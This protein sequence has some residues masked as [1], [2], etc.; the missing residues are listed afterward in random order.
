MTIELHQ[1]K[2]DFDL[3]NP[4]PFCMKAETFMKLAGVD[5]DLKEWAPTKAPLG[6]APVLSIDNELTPDSSDIIRK[7]I[8]TQNLDIDGSVDPM[9]LDLARMATRILEEHSYWGLLFLRWIDDDGWSKYRPIIGSSIGAPSFILPVI[10][11]ML[12]RN[13]KRD[14]KGQGLSRH[15]ADQIIERVIEDIK[16]VEAVLADED[17]LGGKNPCSHDASAFSFIENLGHPLL[18]NDLTAY[19]S[20][21]NRL[22]GYRER[23]RKAAWPEWTFP[24]L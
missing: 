14:A 1:F 11:G 18:Q 12:R 7:V 21:S 8:E 4:S 19:I 20:Q 24:E 10:L 23:M 6:K 17:Y 15:S 5:Y 13:V 22:R 3:P 2:A 9:R 16:G